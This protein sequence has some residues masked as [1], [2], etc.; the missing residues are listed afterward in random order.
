M[1]KGVAG[2]IELGL[3]VVWVRIHNEL[4]HF[5]LLK[6]RHHED[7]FLE[8]GFTDSVLSDVCVPGALC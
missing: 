7:R 1:L 4:A 2:Q 8:I 3:S 6:E 5:S